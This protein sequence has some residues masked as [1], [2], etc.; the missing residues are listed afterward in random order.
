MS[1]IDQHHRRQMVVSI[2]VYKRILYRDTVKQRIFLLTLVTHL[3]GL[4]E[5]YTRFRPKKPIARLEG[6]PIMKNLLF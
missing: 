5:S 1:V 2:E 6:T 4:V 3:S